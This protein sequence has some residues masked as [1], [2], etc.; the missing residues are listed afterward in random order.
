MD[1]IQSV[2]LYNTWEEVGQGRE[3]IRKIR[4]E[5]GQEWEEV[6]QRREEVE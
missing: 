6:G 1:N 5:M 3:E 2:H 4:E